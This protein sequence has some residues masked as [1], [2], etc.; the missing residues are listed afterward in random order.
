MKTFTF[1][2]QLVT[3]LHHIVWT[4]IGISLLVG[5]IY[6][7]TTGYKAFL[8]SPQPQ[9]SLSSSPTLTAEQLD[10]IKHAIGEKRYTEVS[11]STATSTPSPEEQAKIMACVK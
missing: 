3:F 7:F 8:S 2:V 6:F 10:C 11:A 4:I 5:G 9:S 1:I